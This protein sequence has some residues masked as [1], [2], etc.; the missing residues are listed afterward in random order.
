MFEINVKFQPEVCNSCHDLLQKAMSFND[1]A[2]V[3]VKGNDYRNHFLCM[4]KDEAI[5]V[6]HNTDLSEKNGTL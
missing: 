1:A 2:I 5:N 4:S 3:S 6:L